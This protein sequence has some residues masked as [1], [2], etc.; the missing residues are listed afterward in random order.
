M[1]DEETVEYGVCLV[2]AAM[3]GQTLPYVWDAEFRRMK[4]TEVF[5]NRYVLTDC[6]LSVNGFSWLT[7]Y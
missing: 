4:E 1:L 6:S 3:G 5:G 2:L 7:L